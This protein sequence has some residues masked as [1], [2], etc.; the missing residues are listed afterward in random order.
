[1]VHIK[2]LGFVSSLIILILNN[3]LKLYSGGIG[4]VTSIS[5][6]VIDMIAAKLLVFYK[7]PNEPERFD[8]KVGS[9]HLFHR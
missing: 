5:N 1:M 9:K 4:E 2:Y 8:K 7:M 6:T 3:I